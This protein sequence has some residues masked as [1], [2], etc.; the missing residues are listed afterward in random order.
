MKEKIPG[1]GWAWARL[2]LSSARLVSGSRKSEENLGEIEVL[3][4]TLDLSF[5]TETFSRL[6][7]WYSTHGMGSDYKHGEQVGVWSDLSGGE[8]HFDNS[9]GDPR[10]LLDGIKGRPVIAFDGN[11][12]LWTS[13]N[14]DFLTESGYTLLTLARYSGS[15]NRRVISSRNRNFLFGFQG[16]QFL[17]MTSTRRRTVH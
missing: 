17:D 15:S 6:Q 16:N 3:D 7:G 9:S 11:D 14:F 8:R 2:D 13:E 12:L 5:S 1:T 10:L 4:K